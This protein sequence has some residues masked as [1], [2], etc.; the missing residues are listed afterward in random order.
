[1]TLSISRS[2]SVER[3]F[4]GDLL[5]G[6]AKGEIVAYEAMSQ[7]AEIDIRSIWGVVASLREEMATDGYVFE[8]VRNVGLRRLTDGEISVLVPDMRRRKIHGQARRA[9]CELAAIDFNAGM[10]ESQRMSALIGQSLFGAIGA[11][12]TRR[13]ISAIAEH[14]SKAGMALPVQDTIEAFRDIG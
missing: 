5:R 2:R 11:L 6:V 10:T 12:T 13:A 3:Q 1:M 14:V 8:A 9:A 4:V 7:A